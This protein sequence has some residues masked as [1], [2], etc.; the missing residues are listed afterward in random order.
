M[1]GTFAEAVTVV[2]LAGLV[3]AVVGHHVPYA[4][5]GCGLVALLAALQVLPTS[6][7]F[8]GF[9]SE[10]VLLVG[11]TMVM[12]AGLTRT[13][14]TDRMVELVQ[15]VAGPAGARLAERRLLAVL[16]LAA[17]ATGAVLGDVSAMA[18]WLPAVVHLARR[19]ATSPGR[20]LLPT[21]YGVLAGSQVTLIGTA[22]NILAS[23]ILT[24]VP[25]QRGFGLFS[26]A[27]VGL[28]LVLLVVLLAV[29]A[30]PALVPPR[31]AQGQ[32]D[33]D[34]ANLKIY[35]GEVVV[36]DH[37][38][39]HGKHLHEATVL[40]DHG[41]RV[42]ALLPGPVDAAAGGI[43]RRPLGEVS[44]AVSP[45]TVLRAGDHL[46]VQGSAEDLLKAQRSG[47]FELHGE[48]EPA[49][50]TAEAL[51]VSDSGLE[52]R[53]LAELGFRQRYG[54]EVLAVWRHMGP[55]R[56]RLQQ[57]RLRAGDILLLSGPRPAA[58]RLHERLDALL[59]G[60]RGAVQLRRHKAAIAV[61]ILAAFVAGAATGAVDPAAAAVG[62]AALMVLTGCLRSEE[63]LGALDFPIL[64]LLAG[65]VPLGTALQ[66]TAIPAY[67]ASVLLPVAH[68]HGPFVVWVLLFLL[69]TLTTQFLSDVATA[70]LWVPV[71]LKLALVLHMDAR[72]LALA[73]MLGGQ[74]PIVAVGHKV[75]LLV[76]SAGRYSQ[77][78][79]LRYGVP[80]VALF[81]V[82]GLL[83]APHVFP[84]R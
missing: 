53:T 5:V 12:G 21:L 22:G 67:V 33:V 71:A 79:F 47:L 58:L 27:P 37:P 16:V 74:A 54:L 64:L 14:V 42:A 35:Q 2:L 9:G 75:A 41:L 68:T 49:S 72:P 76:P 7:A 45:D 34:F 3:V 38:A 17:A 50:V 1:H 20:L 84:F 18:L 59:L 43:R 28:V 62:G 69:A 40:R 36:A 13:G 63:A 56:T 65:I 60:E 10:L 46:L 77:R 81:L 44:T 78:D 48:S 23:G 8:A 25:G 55:P 82:G 70:L 11:G 32:P 19:H 31:T 61:A 26:Q 83:A 30:G 57:V 52:G 80:A 24:A 73:I 15:R 66:Q 4:V 29:T 6:L 39:I 51:V